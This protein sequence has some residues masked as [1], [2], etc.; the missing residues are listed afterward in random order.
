V[1]DISQEEL[2]SH[3]SVLKDSELLY[4]RGIYPQSTYIFKHALT[5][6]VVYD[7]ILTRGKKKLHEEIGHAIEQLFI[8]NLHEHYG[9]LAEHFISSEN[10]EKGTN[11]CRLAGKKAEKAG[12]LDDSISYGEK[13]VACLEKLPR[14]DD[15]EKNLIDAR[16]KLG[17][18]YLQMI[19]VV[20]AKIAVDPIIDL[21]IKR[22]YKKRISQI[23]C[24][25]GCYKFFVEEDASKSFEYIEK[26]FKIGEELN[27]LPTLVVANHYMTVCQALICEF[28]KS[29]HF[30]EKALE[31]NVTANVPWGIS[32]IK[33]QIPFWVYLCLGKIDLGYETSEEA[34]QI[35]DDSGDIY[36]KAHAYTGHGYSYYYKGY[37]E[38]AKE[39]FLKGADL[40]ERINILLF[41]AAA[42]SGLGIIYFEMG[43]YKLAQKHYEK[44]I[45]VFQ[46][47]STL[48]S[49]VN[50]WKL[51]LSLAKVMNNEKDINLHDI[52][53]CYDNNK[54]EK[55]KGWILHC[56]GEILLNIDDQHISEAEDWIKK[57]IEVHKKYGMMWHLARDYALYAEL[58]NRKGNLP[59]AREKLNKAIEIFKECGADGW[60]KKYEKELATLS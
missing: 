8:G 42:H 58:F 22:N 30:F 41:A 17:L 43:E 47:G 45:S 52:F 13:Q 7:S 23:Y 46:L 44:A 51:T 35:A 59:K 55:L 5:Q 57:A 9:I 34:L 14:T 15:V 6:E 49:W 33:A 31:I 21:A 28:T 24:I 32:A 40:C 26:A 3:L 39:H 36:S 56:I 48:P 38:E 12:S 53:Q 54:I 29:L 11:Y 4:E 20:K 25:V 37:L 50:Y 60:V 10:F 2:L 1:T 18:Y 27:D 19:D 16:T